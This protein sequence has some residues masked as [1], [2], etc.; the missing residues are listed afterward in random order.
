M[1]DFQLPAGPLKHNS[2]VHVGIHA[3][4]RYGAESI[5]EHDM[6]VKLPTTDIL[7]VCNKKY[8]A[9]DWMVLISDVQAYCLHFTVVNI[10]NFCGH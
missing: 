8:L 4:D 1:S 6:K 10:G 2:I 3:I 5:I 9:E 7:K